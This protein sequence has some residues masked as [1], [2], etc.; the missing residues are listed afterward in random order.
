MHMIMK[1]TKMKHIILDIKITS[2]ISY[3][4]LIYMF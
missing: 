1:I 4:G 2:E 3:L